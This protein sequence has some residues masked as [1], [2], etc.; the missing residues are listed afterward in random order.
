[1]NF[2]FNANHKLTSKFIMTV[3][4]LFVLMGCNQATS[5]AVVLPAHKAS[6][7]SCRLPVPANTPVGYW[8][9][10]TNNFQGVFQFLGQTK[11]KNATDPGISGA[12]LE[13]SW[14]KI[15][16]IEGQYDW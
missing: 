1:M 9:M 2:E 3:T 6:S 7:S 4:M 11:P 8:P 14:A 10:N 13:W 5:R 12:N 15:E 16:P